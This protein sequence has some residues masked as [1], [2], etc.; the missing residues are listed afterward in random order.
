MSRVSLRAERLRRNHLGTGIAI[1]P[2][3]LALV[4][5]LGGW[6]EGTHAPLVYVPFLLALG[7]VVA[8]QVWRESPWPH[9][10]QG[11]IA[12][13]DDLVTWCGAALARRSEITRVTYHHEAGAGSIVRVERAQ[14]GDVQLVVR[15]DETARRVVD[16]LGFGA[17]RGV[18]RFVGRSRV[19]GLGKGPRSLLSVAILACSGILASYAESFFRTHSVGAF[20][21][22]LLVGVV[23][24]F[25]LWLAPTTIEVGADALSIRWLGRTRIVPLSEVESIAPMVQVERVSRGR[26]MSGQVRIHHGVSVTLRDGNLV[27]TRFGDGAYH[28]AQRDQLIERVRTML[29][30]R[31]GVQEPAD[32]A[33]LARGERDPSSWIRALRR[34]STDEGGMRRAPI[35]AERFWRV[36]EDPAVEATDRAAAAVAIGGAATQ[37]QRARVRIAADRTVDPALREALERAVDEQADEEA[38]VAALTVLEK[39]RS[40]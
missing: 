30:A 3:L 6:M 34:G 31:E 26:G 14:G 38:L 25:G 9:R 7:V 5:S 11:E 18:A 33:F 36:I 2:F 22:T 35:P 21:G 15:D 37:E 40:A 20:F 27:E 16:A 24:I 39:R 23:C 8:F 17:D 13:E 1:L 4:L 32:T 28:L 29:A 19:F 10:E 12:V